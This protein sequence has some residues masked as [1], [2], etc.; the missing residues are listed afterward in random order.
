MIFVRPSIVIAAGVERGR[1]AS[2][3]RII[4]AALVG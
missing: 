4:T 2:Y 3:G 1:K